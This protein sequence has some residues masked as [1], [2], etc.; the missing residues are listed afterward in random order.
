MLKNLIIRTQNTDPYFNQTLGS[1]ITR[2]WGKS[3]TNNESFH[4]VLFVC[5]NRPS[6]SLGRNQYYFDEFNNN[7]LSSKPIPVT[8]R[9][10]G[11]GATYVDEG[12]VLFSMHKQLAQETDS[13]AGEYP[14]LV[15]TLHKLGFLNAEKNGRN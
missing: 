5:T 12:T 7:V 10:T 4:K 14:I 8:R 1:Y 2:S 3:K 13:L 6:L 15:E 11:G 9:D